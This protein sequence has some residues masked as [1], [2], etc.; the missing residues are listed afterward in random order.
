M[1]T[2]SRNI[3]PGNNFNANEDHNDSDETMRP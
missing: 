2:D 3:M 1:M